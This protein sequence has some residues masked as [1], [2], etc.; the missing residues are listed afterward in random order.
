MK[1]FFLLI[2]MVCFFVS[3]D[4]MAQTKTC[5]KSAQKTCTKGDKSAC[6]KVDGKY[7][8]S[9][10]V[11]AKLVADGYEVKS[12]AMSGSYAT[13]TCAKSGSSSKIAMCSDSG[14]MSKTYTCGASGSVTTSDVTVAEL[15]EGQAVEKEVKVEGTAALPGSKKACCK[16]KAGKTCSKSAAKACTGAKKAEVIE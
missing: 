8:M 14:K 6:T 13:K 5:S 12:C 9:E 10:A 16:S 1:K 3:A 11:Q 4:A 15:L 7:V 2:T